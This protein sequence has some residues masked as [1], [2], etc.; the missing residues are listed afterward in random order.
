MSL[1]NKI[2]V[3]YDP[4]RRIVHL[5]AAEDIH[6]SSREDL[7]EL[8]TFASETLSRHTH[9]SPVYVLV[10]LARFIIDPSLFEYYAEKSAIIKE[11][12]VYPD[13]MAA[14]GFQITRVT[15]Q[16]SYG[17]SEKRPP[18]FKTRR[19]AE[20]HLAGIEIRRKSVTL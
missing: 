7:D 16:L 5:T 9:E 2:I 10:D 15:V 13:G 1:Q 6:F 19:E 12:Y 14:Y 3:E 17:D 8:Y 18:L 4:E 20:E 11:K